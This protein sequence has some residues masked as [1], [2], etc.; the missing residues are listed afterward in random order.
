[1][2]PVF[3]ERRGGKYPDVETTLNI[4]T[5]DFHYIQPR[6]PYV[7]RKKNKRKFAIAATTCAL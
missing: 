4:L 3:R 1:M 5:F 2:L 6:A 7:S